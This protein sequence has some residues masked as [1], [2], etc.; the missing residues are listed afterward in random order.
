[1]RYAEKASAC[2]AC[3]VKSKCTKG[4][5]GRWVSRSLEEEYLERVRAHCDTVPYRKA[6]GK[7]AVWVEPL[8]GEAKQWHGL[9]RF[10]LRRLEKVNAEAL[11]IASGQ[12]VKRLLAFIARR[13]SRPAQVA[14]LRRPEAGRPRFHPGSMESEGI[15]GDASGA[16]RNLF[17]QAG[18]FCE[19][20]LEY[21]LGSPHLT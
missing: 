17:Q 2:N 9:R 20:R 8:F 21:I 7:R 15:A 14:A 3:S 10:R 16:Q 13:P 6:L 5:K 11:M 4:P 19:L 18:V 1:M 12:N